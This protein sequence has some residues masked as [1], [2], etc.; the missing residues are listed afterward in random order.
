M[1]IRRRRNKKQLID[2]GDLAPSV[3]AGLT[4]DVSIEELQAESRESIPGGLKASQHMNRETIISRVPNPHFVGQHKNTGLVRQ[5]QDGRKLVDAEITFTHPFFDAIRGGMMCLKCMEP[6]ETA[7]EDVHL[8]GCEGV[9][10]HGPR[11]MRDFYQVLDISLEFEGDVHIGPSKP[12][13]EVITEKDERAA[14]LAFDLKIA[15][16]GSRGKKN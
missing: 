10:I 11:Y 14:R 4:Q 6:Q 7:N 8:P 2:P 3:A 13:S 12:M 5:A 15:A 16:G 1:S 9:L